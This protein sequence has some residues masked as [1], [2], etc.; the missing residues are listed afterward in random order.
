[1]GKVGVARYVPLPGNSSA[2]D[3]SGVEIGCLLDAGLQVL[4]VQHVRRPPWIPM[5]QSGTVDAGAACRAAELSG[6]PAGCHLFLDFEG[7]AGSPG[8]AFAYC[9]EWGKETRSQGYLAGLY[10]G[11]SALMSPQ[12]LYDLPD[13][14]SYW[15]DAGPRQVAVRGFAIRQHQPEVTIAGVNFDPDTVEP[16]AKG[17][18]PIVCGP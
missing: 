11:Y 2:G 15:S 17:E 3:I 1:V 6:Y 9:C 18:L 5:Q 16:D 7:A 10:V 13:F 4:L 14:T 12:E 8:A